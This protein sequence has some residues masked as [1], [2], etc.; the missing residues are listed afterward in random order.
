MKKRLLFILL[1]FLSFVVNGQE[2]LKIRKVSFK[3]NRFIRSSRLEDAINIKTASGIGEKFFDKS[4]DRYSKALYDENIKLIS[5]LY[6][7]EGFLNVRFYQPEI[8]ITGRDKV[9]LK[10]NLDEGEPVQIDKITYTIDS[11]TVFEDFFNK[12]IR[13]NIRLQSQL[14]VKKRFRD[15]SYYADQTFINGELN[16]MGYAYAQVKHKL[17]VDTINNTAS[18]NWIID[19][20]KQCYFGPIVVEGN[21]RVPK[22]KV[23]KQLKFKTG[24]IWS[25]YE[26]DESQKQIY[27]LGMF[28]VA[29]IKTLLSEEKPDTLPTLV[30]LKEA[31][32]WITRFGVGYGR[33]DNFRVF[34]DIQYMGF[35]TKAGRANLYG[36]HS[37]LEPYNFQFK[38]TQPAILFPF[39]SLIVNPFLLKQDEPGYRIA[40]HG[41]NFTMLQHFTERFNSSINFYLEEVAGDSARVFETKP[42]SLSDSTLAD[43]GKSGISL[44]F[45]YS[46]GQPILDPV[47]GFS[48]AINIKRNGTLVEESVPFYRCL[49]DYRNYLGIKSGLTI[50]LKTKVGMAMLTQSDELVPV[51]ERFFAGGSYSV[52]GWGR[53]QLGPKYPNGQPV[54]GNSLLEG[55]IE[56]RYQISPKIV[57]AAFCD[58]GNVWLDSFKYQLNDLRYSAGFSFRFKTPI[59]PVGLDFAR[60]IFDEEKTWQIHFNI[61]NPF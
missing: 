46:S 53:S 9:K 39:N 16:N 35:V 50:A 45:V 40:R 52:R 51:E 38:F 59:G 5:Y 61:G 47:T 36:K 8:K 41:I 15:E 18:L 57:F 19:K 22:E 26:I 7:K 55:S 6:Q 29:S 27:N 12:K 34:T 3:G 30:A 28:R 23:I 56:T 32:R 24:D 20:G 4:A 11:L 17:K 13:R 37:S 31:P 44:G 10:F 1:F 33:E 60:P 2:L 14:K 49:I 43:Y 48:I 54:G 21:E 25:R 42:L 58:A